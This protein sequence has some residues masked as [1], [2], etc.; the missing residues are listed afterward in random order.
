SQT[1][2]VNVGVGT[3][4]TLSPSFS[5]RQVFQGS[6]AQSLQNERCLRRQRAACRRYPPRQSSQKPTV[7]RRRATA[8][9]GT[10]LP[11]RLIAALPAL[12]GLHRTLVR[13]SRASFC[14]RT[15][16]RELHKARG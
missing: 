11:T 6:L 1:P 5:H 14:T 2:N 15:E 8:A 9:S 16:A 3:A 4:S 12:H 7:E 10:Q 13:S